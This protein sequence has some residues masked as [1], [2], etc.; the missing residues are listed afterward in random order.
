VKKIYPRL[1]PSALTLASRRVGGITGGFRL[2][3]IFT[4]GF[5]TAIV[6]ENYEIDIYIS[7]SITSTKLQF[8]HLLVKMSLKSVTDILGVLEIPAKFQ[9]QPLQILLK[10]L[11][12]VVGLGIAAHARPVSM[13]RDVLRVAT[14]SAS[15]A[16]NLTFERTRLL[17]K[18]NQKL[19]TPLVDI[20]FSSAGWKL[21]PDLEKPKPTVSP[22]EHPSYLGNRVKV[23]REV[24]PTHK[25]PNAA[26][27]FWS[28]SI[29]ER[30]HGL[31]LC[32]QCHSPTP[33]GELKRWSVCSIC[34]AK[35]F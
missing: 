20:R 6:T 25:N 21:P 24:P 14:S 9:E 22:H 31:P 17:L 11:T 15:W 32:P 27:Q 8:L 30:S 19:P 23:R 16:Q 1:S 33:S 28:Q 12:E 5:R 2:T 4:S 18:L 26:F 13:Q 34:V 29:Q 35:E 7:L 10:H 3:L